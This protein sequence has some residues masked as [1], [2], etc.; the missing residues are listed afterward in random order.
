MII[1]LGKSVINYR[2]TDISEWYQSL[3]YHVLGADLDIFN[4]M[5]YGQDK[6]WQHLCPIPNCKQ[7]YFALKNWI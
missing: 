5:Q 1:I 3:N 7:K 6:H 2:E 4:I